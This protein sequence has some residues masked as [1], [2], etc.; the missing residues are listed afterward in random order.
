MYTSKNL[1]IYTS[2]HIHINNH[3][4]MHTYT[5][6]YTCTCTYK[7]IIVTNSDVIALP[8]NPN[9]FTGQILGIA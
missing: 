4:H 5:Y 6:T 7:D 2:M 3:L 8:S 9:Y 1:H